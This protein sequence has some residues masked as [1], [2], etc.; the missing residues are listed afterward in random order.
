[1]QTGCLYST[2]IPLTA[3][4][5]SNKPVCCMRSTERRLQYESA[6]QIEIPSSSLHTRTNLNSG[7]RDSGQSSPALVVISGTATTT[8]IEDLI[9]VEMMALPLSFVSS[10]TSCTSRLLLD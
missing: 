6:E 8:S 9:S 1:M 7:R 2:A 10:F 5:E 3:L 4:R